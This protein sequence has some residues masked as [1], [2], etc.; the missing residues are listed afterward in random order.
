[1]KIPGLKD[2]VDYDVLT[3]PVKLVIDNKDRLLRPMNVTGAIFHHKDIIKI[4]SKKELN[5]LTEFIG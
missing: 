4:I 3:K 1:M 2:S 5:A